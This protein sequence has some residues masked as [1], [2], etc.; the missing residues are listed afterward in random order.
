MRNHSRIPCEEKPQPPKYSAMV[1]RLSRSGSAGAG[2][3]SSDPASSALLKVLATGDEPN[4]SR[5]WGLCMT[6]GSR[7]RSLSSSAGNDVT[8]LSFRTRTCPVSPLNTTPTCR[9]SLPSRKHPEEGHTCTLGR[10]KVETRPE[11]GSTREQRMTPTAVT[12]PA[13]SPTPR[14]E[15][16]CRDVTTRRSSSL[17][18]VDTLACESGW[19]NRMACRT[20]ESADLATMSPGREGPGGVNG[21][22]GIHGRALLECVGTLTLGSSA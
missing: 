14:R 12:R 18:H 4:A 9:A 10:S 13:E 3:G 17:V 11:D 7:H 19:K 21:T 16:A 22:H 1:S 20:E 15:R 5:P 2:A 6:T 8:P